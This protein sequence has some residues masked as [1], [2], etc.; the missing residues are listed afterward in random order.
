MVEDEAS[1][2]LVLH[3]L[4][5]NYTRGADRADEVIMR[6]AFHD[7]AEMETGLAETAID[8]YVPA[9]LARTRR[10]YRT[11]YHSIS[12]E[13]VE[14]AGDR[15]RGECYVTVYAL[16]KDEEPK[17]VRTGGRYLDRFE[18]RAGVWKFVHR[19]YV[20]DWKSIRPAPPES[21]PVPGGAVG[22]FHPTDP[23]VAFWASE[24]GPSPA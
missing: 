7:D 23:A 18:R 24:L 19:Q 15:A 21:P 3:D 1:I 8:R 5:M 14:I 17:E 9:I 22:G 11:M 10:L 4:L 20:Q 2:R 12:N 13:R 6:S 16:T